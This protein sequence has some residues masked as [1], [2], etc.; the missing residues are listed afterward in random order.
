[1]SDTV[2]KAHHKTRE[3]VAEADLVVTLLSGSYAER[4]RTNAHGVLIDPDAYLLAL[5]SAQSAIVRAITLHRQTTWP[6]DRD[7][8]AL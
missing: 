5:V 6:S 1:M 3:I 7:Y 4:S 8:D 2:I